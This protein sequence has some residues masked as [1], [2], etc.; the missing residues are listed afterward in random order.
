MTPAVRIEWRDPHQPM[1]SSFSLEL[2]IGEGA[3]D[4]ERCALDACHVAGLVIYLGN[5]VSVLFSPHDVH[6]VEH[7]GPV[8]TFRAA[9]TGVD[10][11]HGAEL[12]FLEAE[13]LFE[14]ELF[15]HVKGLLVLSFELILPYIS[16][17]VK[18]I[19]HL[20]VIE[21]LAHLVIGVSP[22]FF[23]P[24][25]FQ[26]GFCLLWVVPEIGLMCDALLVLYLGSLAIVV[27]DTSSRRRYDLLDL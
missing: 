20:E 2:A 19:E 15:N 4:L 1:Y 6:A 8:L 25:I 21:L 12:I 14:L 17:I 3:I 10:L 26:N 18:F 5:L 11:D 7:V 13:H 9:S 24:D 22:D 16:G 23:S 27:K